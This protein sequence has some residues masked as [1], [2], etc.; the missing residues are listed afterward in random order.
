MVEIKFYN[1]VY[2]QI[3]SDNP[4]LLVAIYEK[5]S[6]FIDNYQYMPAYNL[7]TFDGKIHLFNSKYNTLPKGLL[8][9]LIRHL[10]SEN[11][12]FT[13]DRRLIPD[14]LPF[15]DEFLSIKHKFPYIAHQR[16]ILQRAL[17]Y[18]SGT[19]ESPTGSGKS[20]IIFALASYFRKYHN[21]KVL[22]TVPKIDLV[23]QLAADFKKYDVHN[24]L[25]NTVQKMHGKLSKDLAP[26]TQ[27]LI[28]TIQTVNKMQPIFFNQF[29]VYIQDEVHHGDTKTS[30][31]VINYLASSAKYRFGLTGTFKNSDI[32]N[33]KGGLNRLQV[34]G[35]F[36]YPIKV[37]DT[38]DLI[39]LDVLPPLKICFY[40]LNHE[41]QVFVDYRDEIEFLISCQKR[42]EMIIKIT[43]ALKGN[44]LILVDRVEHA[45]QLLSLMPDNTHKFIVTGEIFIGE[46]VDNDKTRF[47][48]FIESHENVLVVAT[49]GV[50][51]TGISIN[52]LH[53][54]IF[55]HPSKSNV[56]ILQSIGR[57]LRK[58]PSKE[59]AYI[60]DLVD[61]FGYISYTMSHA[62]KRK[63]IYDNSKF[64]YVI[65]ERE[66]K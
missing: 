17:T 48:E 34:L 23:N 37:A 55:A 65:I 9:I 35:Y 56:R 63:E 33:I 43:S 8:P 27:V 13:L 66:L 2:A 42:N 53:N 30:V 46:A 24:I 28:A 45:K 36:G 5:F 21:L 4:D 25:S 60:I 1:E 49:Y 14:D 19:I 52:N 51:S 32:N 7:R 20:M 47:I 6:F 18:S 59:Y 11:I 54:L 64:N 29:T 16:E 39:D 26:E 62:K 38:K 15:I 58:H 12:E 3:L 22:I 57:A 50:F 61:F 31:K 44:T 10:K 41:S 40:R